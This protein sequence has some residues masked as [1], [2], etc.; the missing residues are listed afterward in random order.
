MRG[1]TH[2][3]ARMDEQ[4][5]KMQRLAQIEDPAAL[6]EGVLTHA[7]IALQL[8]ALDGQ[9]LFV[10]RAF[11]ELFG[12]EPAPESNVHRDEVPIPTPRTLFDRAL[13][14]QTAHEGPSWYELEVRPS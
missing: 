1:A 2:A 8:V 12:V 13:Q 4:S 9:S 10:N 3:G 6:L 5:T 11:V 7:P 14:G